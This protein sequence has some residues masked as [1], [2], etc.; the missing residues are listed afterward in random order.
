M[1]VSQVKIN[2]SAH[3]GLLQYCSQQLSYRNSQDAPL[4]MNGIRKCCIY[5]QWY[6][7]RPHGMK[8]CRLLVNGWKWRPSP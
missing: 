5:I 7:I 3:P 1:S 6:F 8:F 4:L 2:V